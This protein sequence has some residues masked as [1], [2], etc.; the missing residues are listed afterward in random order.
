MDT[1]TAATLGNIWAQMLNAFLYGSQISGDEFAAKYN[2]LAA[3]DKRGTMITLEDRDQLMRLLHVSENVVASDAN[4]RV[5][6][7]SLAKVSI[8]EFIVMLARGF[9]GSD[10]KR[11]NVLYPEY[12]YAPNQYEGESADWYMLLKLLG[13]SKADAKRIQYIICNR[14]LVQIFLNTRHQM[15]T[16]LDASKFQT[17]FIETL[18]SELDADTLLRC[19]LEVLEQSL[20]VYQYTSEKYGGFV[21]SKAADVSMQSMTSNKALMT[22]GNTIRLIDNVYNYDPTLAMFG[23]IDYVK[24][25]VGVVV[26]DGEEYEEVIPDAHAL[27]GSITVG[28]LDDHTNDMF[29]SL[30]A[31]YGEYADSNMNRLPKEK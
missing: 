26:D 18:K 22:S 13:I 10:G 11:R 8:A 30:V 21:T 19:S 6:D 2:E 1:Y 7:K 3:R 14:E 9:K 24:C 16:E 28:D 31:G 15:L 12:F 23:L 29:N 4:I 17:L 20:P 27:V 25:H 5:F